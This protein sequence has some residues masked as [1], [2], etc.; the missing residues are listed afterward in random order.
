MA[1][2][3]S[4]HLPSMWLAL[5]VA[6]A[7]EPITLWSMQWIHCIDHRVIGSTASATTRANHM[8]GKCIDGFC[9]IGRSD[10]Q[11]VGIWTKQAGWHCERDLAIVAGCG[12][13]VGSPQHQGAGST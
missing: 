2:K 11:L 1:Q 13:D 3:P 10:L 9:A 12:G 5:V 6:E 4:M 8:E 7:V